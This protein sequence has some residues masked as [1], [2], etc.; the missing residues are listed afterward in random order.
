[1]RSAV[2][3]TL[4]VVLLPAGSLGW[5]GAEVTG[6]WGDLHHHVEVTASPVPGWCY[7]E[8]DEGQAVGFFATQ[9]EGGY[10]SYC[11]DPWQVECA[12]DSLVYA[13]GW[14]VFEAPLFLA[15]TYQVDLACALE[16]I[17]STA[18]V[19]ERSV[20]GDLDTD[21][22]TVILW[23]P[24]DLEYAVLASGSGGDRASVV[25]IPGSYELHI[26]IDVR[27]NRPVLPYSGRVVVR[28]GDP[29][30]LPAEGASWG[31]VKALFRD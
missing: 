3:I 15:A 5:E 29:E 11:E 9:T 26:V 20:A 23:F 24:G 14:P 31:R 17:A 30:V 13:G 8:L 10:G 25:L 21:A 28:W 18:L 27:D 2:L 4:L 12:G 6:A 22:H 1:M 7:W 16:V 19:A